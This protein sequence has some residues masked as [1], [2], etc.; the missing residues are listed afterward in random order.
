M[1]IIFFIMPNRMNES[2]VLYYTCSILFKNVAAFTFHIIMD[3]FN[4]AL[5]E[6]K[7]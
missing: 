6:S 2:T 7:N 3:S 4:P 1:K 5:S